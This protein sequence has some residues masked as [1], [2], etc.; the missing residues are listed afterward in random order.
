M[1]VACFALC[2]SAACHGDPAG[3]RDPDPIAVAA[4]RRFVEL[5]DSVHGAGGPD[6]LAHA[7]IGIAVTLERQSRA[8]PVRLVVDGV[9]EDWLATARE[10]AYYEAPCPANAVCTPSINVPLESVIAWKR[11]DPTRVVQLT[12]H[13]DAAD[14]GASG[15]DY[16]QAPFTG[17]A[18]LTYLDGHGGVFEAATGKQ[19][20]SVTHTDRSCA[21]ARIL[22]AAAS[23]DGTC[24]AATF[25]TAFSA[26]VAPPMLF[27]PSGNTASGTHTIALASTGVEGARLEL[28]GCGT[29]YPNYGFPAA[30]LPPISL[31][32]TTT[33][34]SVLRVAMDS[35]ATFT[36]DV[37]NR[38]A[39]PAVVAFP[40]AQQYDFVVSAGFPAATVWRWSADRSFAATP[41]SRTLAPG[42][43]WVIAERWHPPAT[44]FYTVRGLLTSTSHFAESVNLLDAR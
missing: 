20:V 32:G 38:G 1:L 39:S 43:H 36:L 25:H 37:M 24:T 19:S 42:E 27:S 18:S 23:N 8:T 28:T 35:V 13:A 5:S 26:T 4:E 3:L 34:A 2:A 33:L 21:P 17:P 31:R 9:A 44:G 10:L 7:Y 16:V 11:D 12:S 15:F 29:C 14:I 30:L 22:A 41:T 40:A 6:V